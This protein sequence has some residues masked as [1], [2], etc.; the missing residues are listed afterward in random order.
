MAPHF[1]SAGFADTEMVN[2]TAGQVLEQSTGMVN[3]NGNF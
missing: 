1:L 2:S 3:H